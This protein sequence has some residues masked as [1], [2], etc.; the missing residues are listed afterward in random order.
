[1]LDLYIDADACPVKDE[2][3]RV[4][5]RYELA[6][7]VV[8]NRRMRVPERGAVS[9]VVVGQG[10]DE[11]DKWIAAHAQPGDIV[12]TADLP[13]AARCIDAGARV[14][15]PRGRVFTEE[16]IGAALA[17]RDLM[18]TLRSAGPGAEEALGGG[19]PPFQRK[20]RSAFLSRLDELVNAIRRGA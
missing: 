12:V 17:T 5:L 13:L 1:M 2:A 14:L 3:Y 11:A 4:A 7:I 8:S 16:S 10:S 20:D 9:L 18:T 15:T 6:V 19:P